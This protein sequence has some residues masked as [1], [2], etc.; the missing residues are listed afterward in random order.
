MVIFRLAEMYLLKAEAL[1]KKKRPDMEAALT[2]LD[3]IRILAGLEA[4]IGGEASLYEEVADERSRELFLEG[5]RLFDWVRTGFY[6]K[7]SRQGIYSQD[8]YTREGYLWPVN[9]QLIIKNKY[10]R[11]TPY[12]ADQMFN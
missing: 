10:V 2:Y 3:K 7:K 1:I 6:A 4:Y 12:W 11:Q 9:F 5:H 8:R